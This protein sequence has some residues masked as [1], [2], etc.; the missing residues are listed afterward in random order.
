[1]TPKSSNKSPPTAFGFARLRIASAILL[2]TTRPKS[3]NRTTLERREWTADDKAFLFMPERGMQEPSK[4]EK[5]PG[6]VFLELLLNPW[7][8]RQLEGSEKTGL[9]N[10][11]LATSFLALSVAA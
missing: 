6:G 10:L 2:C 9:L 1:M 3:A 5:E 8:V 7:K 11:F 4:M